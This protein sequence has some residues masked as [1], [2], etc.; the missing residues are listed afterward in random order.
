M[1]KTTAHSNARSLTHW[2]RPGIKPTSSWILV[3]FVSAEPG[4][5]LLIH[6]IWNVDESQKTWG[7]AKET[8]HKKT[9]L[10]DSIFMKFKN[11]GNQYYYNR[12]QR[13]LTSGVGMGDVAWRGRKETSVGWKCSGSW[14]GCEYIVA[15]VHFTAYK[16]YLNFFKYRIK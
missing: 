1:T 4:Q 9:I 6:A 2:S 11:K 16:L 12:S 14:S 3:G 5:E 15:F 7:W 10:C 8:E 13:V